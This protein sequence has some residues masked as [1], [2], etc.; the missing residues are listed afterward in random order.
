MALP[1][2]TQ[3]QLQKMQDNCR[4]HARVAARHGVMRGLDPNTLG[5]FLLAEGWAMIWGID[6]DRALTLVRY[7]N[8]YALEILGQGVIDRIE[9][10]GE[11][12]LTSLRNQLR[13]DVAE[14]EAAALSALKARVKQRVED[15]RD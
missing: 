2:K 12:D 10:A 5:V 3:A 15:R 9:G 14:L 6:I 1:T 11:A 13:A 7:T 4:A 8:A